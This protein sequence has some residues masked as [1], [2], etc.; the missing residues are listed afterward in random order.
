M[1]QRTRS[2]IVTVAVM[3]AIL[4]GGEVGLRLYAYYFRHPYQVLDPRLG[5]IRLVPGYQASFYGK[6]LR[7]NSLGFRGNEFAPEKP[8]SVFRIVTLGDSVTFGLFG[9]GCAYPDVLQ[10]RFNEGRPGRVEVINAGVEGYD[11]QD[12][13]RILQLKLMDYSPDLITVMVGWNDLLKR[14]P[15][16]PDA[17][18]MK[19][20]LAYALYDIYLIK[21]WRSVVYRHARHALFRPSMDLPPAEEAALRTYVPLVYKENLE[22]IVRTAK[23]GG[24]QVVLLALHSLLRPDMTP[25][26]VQKLYFPYYT[27]NVKKYWLLYQQY[28][29]TVRTVGRELGVPV[30]EPATVL[31]GRESELYMDTVHL[32]CAGHQIFGA[33]LHDVLSGLIEK[34]AGSAALRGRRS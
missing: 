6:V 19:A 4:L 9:D 27:Y 12:V 23:A 11:S 24:S 14:D 15:G 18:V 1:R 3:L 31:R 28:S 30:V 2:L 20:R 21:F 33:Y 16:Q 25:D 8:N 10:R 7:I 29:E 32:D 5:M 13:L 22:K 34:G 26:D 17:S